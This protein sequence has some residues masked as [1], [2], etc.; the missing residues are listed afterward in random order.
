[1]STGIWP[2]VVQPDSIGGLDQSHITLA[3]RLSKIGYRTGHVG[4][5]HLGSFR[6]SYLPTS[7]GF[8]N[9]FGPWTGK[10]DYFDHTDMET[11]CYII[12]SEDMQ[13]S[14]LYTYL[15]GYA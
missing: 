12:L 7:R 11:V 8:Q 2:K 1:M 9:H 14:V 4:K 3:T 10:H 6:S 15:N 13:I 5:W